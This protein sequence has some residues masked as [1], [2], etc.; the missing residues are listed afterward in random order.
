MSAIEAQAA[1]LLVSRDLF[2]SSKITGTAGELG[3]TI[4]VEGDVEQAKSRLAGSSYRCVL[5]DLGLAGL[6]VADLVAALP[7][8]GRPRTVAFGAHVQTARLEE[9]RAAGCDDVMPRSR[10]SATLPQVL[11]ECLGS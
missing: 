7:Q 5:I 4:D 6:S 10:F 8:E 2:F 11:K 9:A 3:L 1:G